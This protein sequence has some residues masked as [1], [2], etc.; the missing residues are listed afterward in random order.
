MTM[1]PTKF[2]TNTT[3]TADVAH[4]GDHTAR[5]FG[6]LRCPHCLRGRLRASSVRDVGD[7]EYALTCQLCHND[8]LTITHG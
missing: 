2:E 3:T 8:A 7:G 6:L 4:V 5:V 1:M